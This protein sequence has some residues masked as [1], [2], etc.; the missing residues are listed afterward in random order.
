MSALRAAL[1][2]PREKLEKFQT[3]AHIGGVVAAVLGIVSALLPWSYAHEPLDDVAYGGAPSPL[4]YNY[5]GF[6]V[7]AAV[8]FAA[9]LV[10]R[11][12][13]K[14]RDWVA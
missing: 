9:P 10:F 12:P 4:Q 8:V 1:T 3:A 14:V 6:A 2:I 13:G 5:I 7:I 11:K